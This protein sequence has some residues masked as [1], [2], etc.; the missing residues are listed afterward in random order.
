[1][2]AAI[3]SKFQPASFPV[4]LPDDPSA[5]RVPID[6][7]APAIEAMADFR[8]VPPLLVGCSSTLEET[9]QLMKRGGA[10]F[11]CVVEP[12]GKLLGSASWHDIQGERPKLWLEAAAAS[13]RRLSWAQVRVVDVM[14]PVAAWQVLELEQVAGLRAADVA[15]LLAGSGRHYVVVVEPAAVARARQ[16][17]GL[18][19]LAS[20]ESLLGRGD[21]SGAVP[22]GMTS[23]T[24]REGATIS[25]TFA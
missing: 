11:A 1:M 21:G 12:D 18:F 2:S 15:A 9:L 7:D 14:E 10:R 4:L 23:V 5:R 17:R 13:G 16:L 24:S 20:L 8:L 19:S 6:P 3:P 25:L 22:R